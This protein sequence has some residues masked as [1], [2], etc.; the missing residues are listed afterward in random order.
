[1]EKE[2]SVDLIKRLINNNISKEELDALLEGIDSEENSKVYEKSLRSHFD[3]IM[4]QYKCNKEEGKT[5]KIKIN[6][7]TKDYPKQ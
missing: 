6:G 7:K 5:E 3:E 2:N 1:M 4:M